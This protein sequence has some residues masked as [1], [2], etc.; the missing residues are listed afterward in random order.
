[1][2]AFEGEA[3][4]ETQVLMLQLYK[5]SVAQKSHLLSCHINLLQSRF[6]TIQNNIKMAYR[7]LN[8]ALDTANNNGLTT[9]ENQIIS[10][11]GNL[12][13][14]IQNWANL[15]KKESGGEDISKVNLI[16]YLDEM[17]KYVNLY[18][19]EQTVEN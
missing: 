14:E 9:L 11:R 15:L 17:L 19:N 10:E 3:I 6:A 18:T 12:E 13:N 16:K 7:H 5:L 1:L 8:M 4:E 2:N